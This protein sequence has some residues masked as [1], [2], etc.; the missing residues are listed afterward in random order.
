MKNK[1]LCLITVGF[2]FLAAC[3]KKETVA[4][5]PPA[6]TLYGTWL[7][8]NTPVSD[9]THYYYVFP[10]DGSNYFYQ[11]SEDKYGFREI[12]ATGVFSATDKQVT[13]GAMGV[14]NYRSTNDSLILNV[15]PSSEV[16]ALRVTNPAFTEKTF[17]HEL[18]ILKTGKAMPGLGN[19]DYGFGFNGDTMFFNYTIMGAIRGYKYDLDNDTILDFWALGANG[20]LHYNAGLIFH[21]YSINFRLAKK[22]DVHSASINYASAN[23]LTDIRNLSM[24]TSSN[25][26]FAYQFDKNM[27]TGVDGGTFTQFYDFT[28]YSAD[29]VVYYNSDVYLLQRG[30]YLYKVKIA[31]AFHVLSSYKLPN[32]YT[33]N[34]MASNGSEVWVYAKNNSTSNYEFLKVSLP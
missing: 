33:L 15:S 31:P 18:P 17:L 26:I 4:Y 11:L 1:I 32:A 34:V 30:N 21:A 24:N 23:Q 9:S 3:S 27:Y 29:H 20:S 12:I 10:N 22:Q 2:V 16:V 8:V 7:V 13:L 25:F 5:N 14:L 28:N 6:A 19:F